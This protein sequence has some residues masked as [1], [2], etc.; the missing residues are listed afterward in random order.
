MT[1]HGGRLLS[2][3]FFFSP[4]YMHVYLCYKYYALVSFWRAS[5]ILN[6]RTVVQ[7]WWQYYSIVKVITHFCSVIVSQFILYYSVL[8]LKSVQSFHWTCIL[9]VF[10]DTCIVKDTSL[11]HSVFCHCVVAIVDFVSCFRL[12]NAMALESAFTCSLLSFLSCAWLQWYILTTDFVRDDSL[13]SIASNLIS[14]SI[15]LC[16]TLYVGITSHLCTI[17]YWVFTMQCL[18]H[19]ITSTVEHMM[20]ATPRGRYLNR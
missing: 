7:F 20:N 17:N 11:L 10:F 6:C 1:F 4:K 2:L 8:I 14:N 18:P 3:F 15:S 19:L 9:D 5:S 13:S 16:H 12:P